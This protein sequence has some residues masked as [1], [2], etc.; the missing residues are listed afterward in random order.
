M[1]DTERTAAAAQAALASALRNLGRMVV[2]QN[3]PEVFFS[4]QREELA[5]AAELC[6]GCPVFRL[7]REAGKF[8]AWGVW[9]GRVSTSETLLR[10]AA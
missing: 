1:T 5:E 6:T 10:R 9:G 3:D 8:E 4:V 2:C 7:C